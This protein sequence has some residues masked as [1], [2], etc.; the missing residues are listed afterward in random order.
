M[1]MSL[2]VHGSLVLMW[3]ILMKGSFVVGP[4]QASNFLNLNKFILFV[5]H[6]SSVVHGRHHCVLDGHHQM[7]DGHQTRGSMMAAI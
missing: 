6:K 2:W 3:S 4:P 1:K 5:E 7:I